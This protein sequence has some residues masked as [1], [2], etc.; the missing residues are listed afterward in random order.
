M[1][2]LPFWL[3]VLATAS[4]VLAGLCALIITVDILRGHRQKMW[5]MDLVWPITAL[6]SGPLGLWAYFAVG[7]LS[8]NAAIQRARA[9]D[10]KPPAQQKPFWQSVAV[11]VTHCGSGCTLGDIAAEWFVVAVPV[12]IAGSTIF[13]TW[14]LD[15]ILAF[16]LGIAFHYFTIQPMRD[17]SVKEGLKAAL[18]ADTLSLSAWQVGMYGWMALT[19]FAFFSPEMLPKSQPTFWFMMQ[20][21]MIFGFLTSYP[22]NWW[23]LRK[24]WKETM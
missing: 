22:V 15:F 6:W 4:L 12:S 24:G 21:A 14:T 18:K 7:R 16:L 19:L 20:I 23:L 13:G 8:T 9:Q 17:L 5:I 3:P 2:T 1:K 10:H 11:G